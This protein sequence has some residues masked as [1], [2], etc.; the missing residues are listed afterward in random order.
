L[1]AVVTPGQSKDDVHAF[2]EARW[3]GFTTAY[4]VPMRVERPRKG[5]PVLRGEH[6]LKS[7]FGGGKYFYK[8]TLNNEDFRARY[9]SAYDTGTFELHKTATPQS[10]Q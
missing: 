5:E 3:H 8:G 7:L 1:R 4:E 6:D 9:E 10:H 2:F